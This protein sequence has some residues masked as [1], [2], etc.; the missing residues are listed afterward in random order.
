MTSATLQP[1]QV[2][3]DLGSATTGWAMGGR[4]DETSPFAER[5][6]LPNYALGKFILREISIFSCRG[7]YF[8]FLLVVCT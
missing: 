8:V 4:G 1:L 7:D 2:A 6:S 5:A 3:I